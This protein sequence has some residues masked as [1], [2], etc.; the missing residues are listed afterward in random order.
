[1]YS[2][3]YS[4]RDGLLLRFAKSQLNLLGFCA[5]TGDFT[6]E[7]QEWFLLIILTPA[8][9]FWVQNIKNIVHFLCV[10]W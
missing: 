2:L 3:M 1:M 10:P 7:V 8:C 6:L 5:F 9:L 4:L